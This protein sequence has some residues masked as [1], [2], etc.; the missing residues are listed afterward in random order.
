MVFF[1][2]SDESVK[3]EQTGQETIE[4]VKKPEQPNQLTTITDQTS[5]PIAVMTSE[6]V[7]RRP[8]VRRRNCIL[9][10]IVSAQILLM[11]GIKQPNPFYISFDYL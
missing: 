10:L 11:S 5:T 3:T 2:E 7:C 6:L 4:E 8:S 9:L 1:N